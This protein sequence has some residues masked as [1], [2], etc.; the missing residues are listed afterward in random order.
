M[1][2]EVDFGEWGTQ[3]LNPGQEAWWWYTWIFD[4]DH[5]SRMSAVPTSYSP[6]GSSVQ[7]VEEWATG[8]TLRVHWKNNGTTPVFWRPTVIVAPSRY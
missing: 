2:V 5:W 4:G 6:A 8:G 1:S 3:W 7:I